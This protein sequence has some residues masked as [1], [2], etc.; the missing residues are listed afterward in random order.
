MDQEWN[1]QLAEAIWCH[2]ER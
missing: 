1:L 2:R